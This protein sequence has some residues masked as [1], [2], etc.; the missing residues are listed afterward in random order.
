M[1]EWEDEPYEPVELD[2]THCADSALDNVSL[3]PKVCFIPGKV[4]HVHLD[5]SRKDIPWVDS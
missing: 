5:S 2:A 1:G 3:L 4:V